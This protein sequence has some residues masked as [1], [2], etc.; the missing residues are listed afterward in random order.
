M[1]ADTIVF[2]L[3]SVPNRELAIKLGGIFPNFHMIG[4][5]LDP[6]TAMAA[7]YEGSRVAREI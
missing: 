6:R 7:V 1:K 4:D 5:C 2:A 3:G